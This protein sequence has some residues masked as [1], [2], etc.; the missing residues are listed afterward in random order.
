MTIGQNCPTGRIARK[1]CPNLLAPANQRINY[2]RRKNLII[3]YLEGTDFAI[4]F[5]QIPERRVSM[6]RQI[7]VHNQLITMYSWDGGRSWCS[8][9]KAMLSFHRRKD[10]VL[11]TRLT[12]KELKWIDSLNQPED[13]FDVGEIQSTTRLQ[14][15]GRS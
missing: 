13:V 14:S 8:S 6:V 9:V 3:P 7:K 4:V 15:G 1:T 10:Q 12:P 2:W 11:K 5:L